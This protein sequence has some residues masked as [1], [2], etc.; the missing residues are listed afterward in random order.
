MWDKANEQTFTKAEA[1]AMQGRTVNT[2]AG[3]TATI[4][5]MFCDGPDSYILTDERGNMLYKSHN[6]CPYVTD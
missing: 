5:G 6:N 2:S 4:K 3:C 1:T